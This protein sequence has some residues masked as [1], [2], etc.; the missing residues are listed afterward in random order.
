MVLVSVALT[1][2][3]FKE[4]HPHLVEYV[5]PYAPMKEKTSR[6]IIQKFLKKHVKN[7]DKLLVFADKRSDKMVNLIILKEECRK[8]SIDLDISLYCEDPDNEGSYFFKEVNLEM[9]V[10]MKGMAIW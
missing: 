7:G 3:T 6:K 1:K 10:E 8:A 2:S 5:L 4:S 9:S